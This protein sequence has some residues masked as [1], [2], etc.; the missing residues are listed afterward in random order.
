[1]SEP[2]EDEVV[3]VGHDGRIWT[4]RNTRD[5]FDR[6]RVFAAIGRGDPNPFP[7]IHLWRTPR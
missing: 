1:M 6:L 4:R 2:D 3:M 7:R 5:F